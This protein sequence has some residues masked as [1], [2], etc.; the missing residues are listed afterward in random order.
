MNYCDTFRGKPFNAKRLYL[1]QIVKGQGEVGVGKGKVYKM[2]DGYF[3]K[4]DGVPF[5]TALYEPG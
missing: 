5:D 1:V 2:R 3:T 4:S